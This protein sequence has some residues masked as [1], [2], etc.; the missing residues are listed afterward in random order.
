VQKTDSNET[1]RRQTPTGA[2]DDD[3]DDEK[4]KRYWLENKIVKI[5]SA[6]NLPP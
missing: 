1:R 3:D 2:D 5:N 6:L 4:Q